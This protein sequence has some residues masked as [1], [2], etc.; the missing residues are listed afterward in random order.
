MG[1]FDRLINKAFPKKPQPAT[2]TM[3]NPAAIAE[4]A[5]GVGR[6]I[7]RDGQYRKAGVK[8]EKEYWNERPYDV[9][10]FSRDIPKPWGDAPNAPNMTQY[11]NSKTGELEDQFKVGQNDNLWLQMRNQKIDKELA[12]NRD[13]AA[14]DSMNQYNAGVNRLG[15][16]GGVDAGS[17]ERLARQS[18]RSQLGNLQSAANTA[19]MSRSNAA[20]QH[21]G[22][23]Q[24]SDRFNKMNALTALGRQDDWN[25]GLYNNTM[26]W[27]AADRMANAYG[28]DGGGEGKGSYVDQW[29]DMDERTSGMLPDDPL[30]KWQKDKARGFIRNQGNKIWGG[31]SDDR[32]G[33]ISVGGKTYASW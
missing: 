5:R 8:A 7:V 12:Q 17:R 11:V 19:G 1:A 33:S 30:T 6:N 28:A 14:A 2:P 25:Q 27:Q 4:A 13:M 9:R 23:L 26:G 22:M 31:N 29:A 20:I 16:T 32:N 10:Q 3:P 24:E 18:Q 15:M 21:A